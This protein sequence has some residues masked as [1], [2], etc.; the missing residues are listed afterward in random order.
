MFG[1]FVVVV[2]QRHV[3]AACEF[4]R[5]VR[6]GGDMSVAFAISDADAR[7][8]CSLRLQQ[9]PNFG[10]G[11]GVV[12]DAQLPVRIELRADGS[13]RA[14]EPGEVGV[15]DRHDHRDQRP[16]RKRVDRI[17]DQLAIGVAQLVVIGDPVAIAAL[18]R[19]ASLAPAELD[20]MRKGIGAA[21]G[22]VGV[23]LQIGLGVE[24]VTGI[25]PFSRAALHVVPDRIVAFRH[26][27]IL[28]A[29]PGLVEQ[30][31]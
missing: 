25:A 24:L 4:E 13:D 6:V 20:V 5:G 22:N 2:H 23:V 1:E 31:G 21:C 11:R 17:A 26:I 18:V 15:V 10:I 14:L 19:R 8:A 27:G 28:R 30:A 9:S 29:V 16:R 7:V 12:G 3:V